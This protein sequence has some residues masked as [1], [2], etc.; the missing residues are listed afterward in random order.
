MGPRRIKTFSGFMASLVSVR[1]SSRGGCPVWFGPIRNGT[2]ASPNECAMSLKAF[3]RK[4]ATYHPLSFKNK[5][6]RKMQTQCHDRSRGSFLESSKIE[7]PGG[8]MTE[9]TR[10]WA[11]V[12]TDRIPVLKRSDDSCRKIVRWL[13]SGVHGCSWQAAE[14]R[15]SSHGREGWLPQLMSD[16]E[17]R[18]ERSTPSLLLDSKSSHDGR[19]VIKP[20]LTLLC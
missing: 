4:T 10:H 17:S 13:V 1:R 5:V 18:N 8:Q 11:F 20:V 15:E 19:N 9:P 2:L 16:G 7:L 3:G 6:G 12:P 14:N